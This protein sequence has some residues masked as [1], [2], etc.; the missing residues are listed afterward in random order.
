ME[1]SPW[2]M[3]TNWLRFDVLLAL[4]CMVGLSKHTQIQH[5]EAQS[6]MSK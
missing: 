5:A 2:P 6:A 1:L 3:A 4:G